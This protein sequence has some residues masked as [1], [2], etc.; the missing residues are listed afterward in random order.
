[1]QATRAL[2][3]REQQEIS[4]HL[5]RVIFYLKRR[6]RTLLAHHPQ[7]WV[8]KD[9]DFCSNPHNTVVL[10]TLINY[11]N[12]PQEMTS[13]YHTSNLWDRKLRAG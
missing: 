13:Y 6:L 10:I 3:H 4:L 5:P 9:T 11:N 1:M 2:L 7:S 12:K 8:P